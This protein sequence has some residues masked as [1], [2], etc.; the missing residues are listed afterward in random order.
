MPRYRV[1][2]GFER[3]WED[4]DDPLRYGQGKVYVNTEKQ[5]RSGSAEEKEILRTIG[6]NFGYIKVGLQAIVE[7]DEDEELK[8]VSDNSDRF[9]TN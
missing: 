7:V 6:M 1:N 3:A 2:Y 4:E 5:I 9:K 8:I